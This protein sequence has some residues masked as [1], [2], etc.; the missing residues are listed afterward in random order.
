MV[1]TRKFSQFQGPSPIQSG[2]IVVGLRTVDG[3]YVNYQFTGV[4]SGSGN[5]GG[6]V[7]VIDQDMHGFEGGEWVRVNS[8]GLYVPAQADSAQDA[9]IAGLVLITG[10][11]QNQFTLQI[12]G[13]VDD[14]S[15]AN[16]YA[17][18]FQ[19]GQVWFL[20]D[21]NPG[22]M[23][24]NEPTTNGFVSIPVFISTG[25]DGKGW[26]RHWRGFIVGGQP[27]ASSGSGSN[28]NIVVINQANA[29]NLGD[30]VY[31]DGAG[32]YQQSSGINLASA[33]AVGV[34][35]Q[36]GNPF[37]LQ[38]EGY[39]ANAIVTDAAGANLVP[40]GVYYVSD[41]PL[42]PGRVTLA[43]PITIGHATKP[44]FICESAGL[45]FSTGYIMP[46]RPLEVTAASSSPP[47]I[48]QANQNAQVVDPVQGGP[49][50]FAVGE[51]L[52]IDEYNAGLNQVNY[53]LAEA[54]SLEMAQAVGVVIAAGNPV[55]TIQT[56]GYN[57]GAV[58]L[59]DAGMPVESGNIY[60]ITGSHAN[61]GK[62]TANPPNGATQY[63]KP[64]FVCEQTAADNGIYA[65][66]ILPQ[67]PLLSSVVAG[68]GGGGG[69]YA[70]IFNQ[71]YN[72]V[73]NIDL[74]NIFSAGT[75]N[76]QI[77]LSNVV[78]S[79]NAVILQCYFG[80]GPGPTWQN[81]N[82]RGGISTNDVGQPNTTLAALDISGNAQNGFN[83]T[84]SNALGT[85]YGGILNVFNAN[86]T[87]NWPLIN[88][89]AT[90]IGASSPNIPYTSDGGG[91]WR[92]NGPVT[93]LRI[94]PS[95]G[96]LITASVQV[97][98]VS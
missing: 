3:R 60:Y 86:A 68:G 18:Q 97:F 57:Q 45:G 96:T 85:N 70:P 61:A 48:Y 14:S 42:T 20:S 8:A 74:V 10:L 39:N 15:F 52:Y 89:Q 49:R 47:N 5:S 88:V 22:E 64:V 63:N 27:G 33:Q 53:A 7:K 2:D 43:P 84:L 75:N 83:L 59:D 34:V 71:N 35:I 17:G 23:T 92:S 46:Q 6:I 76:Y 58:T 36:T 4:G 29:F 56:E 78:P 13:Y 82:W 16:D 98:A 25:T 1:Q 87:V 51:W 73:A 62:I 90:Y 19:P 72:N 66:V 28:P 69:G 32:V 12:I 44:I 81:N 11:T 24:L 21:T 65:G 93:S 38:T 31:I 9:E 50:N 30:V 80:T 41:N 79:N 77:I 94:F 37:T 67:R 26:I 55:F 91:H 54:N 95:A 40:G